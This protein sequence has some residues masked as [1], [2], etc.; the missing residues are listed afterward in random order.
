M[1]KSIGMQRTSCSCVH[2]SCATSE[3]PR[4]LCERICS[5]ST[6]TSFATCSCLSCT[7][8]GMSRFAPS[9]RGRKVDA[10][11]RGRSHTLAVL[12]MPRYAPYT[13]T[14][15]CIPVYIYMYASRTMLAVCLSV[16]R[17]RISLPVV[18]PCAALSHSLL[19]QPQRLFMSICM[20]A[21][22]MMILSGRERDWHLHRGIEPA[23]LLRL[24]VRPSVPDGNHHARMPGDR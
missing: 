20:C 18:A 5:S 1:T 4:C 10:V 14:H 15:T 3:L 12:E 2:S 9:P 11:N 22:M 8:E 17:V 7:T 24:E 23:A 16:C 6:A 13:Y 19:T 21:I